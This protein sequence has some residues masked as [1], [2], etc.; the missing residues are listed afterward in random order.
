M[1]TSQIRPDSPDFYTNT[2]IDT[3]GQSPPSTPRSS[4]S[5]P[6]V[7]PTPP[8]TPPPTR[9]LD[10]Q[11]ISTPPPGQLVT[12]PA[13][14]TSLDRG[15]PIP[16]VTLPSSRLPIAEVARRVDSELAQRDEAQRAIRR[17]NTHVEQ[18]RTPR[19]ILQNLPDGVNHRIQKT[20]HRRQNRKTKAKQKPV[21]CRPCG[22]VYPNADQYDAHLHSRRH[23]LKAVWVSRRC[24]FCN[25]LFFSPEDLRRHCRSKHNQNPSNLGTLPF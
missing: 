20:I 13:L 18:L 16:R 1:T 25:Q 19:H 11:E 4:T 9:A 6:F 8:T 21:H 7:P 23:F 2:D 12:P 17:I 22:K 3:P 10:P 15:T 5:D 24:E 14:V